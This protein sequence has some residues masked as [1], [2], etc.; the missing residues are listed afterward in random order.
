M[1]EKPT[2]GSPVFGTFSGRMPKT[3]KDVNV[4]LLFTVLT[5]GMKS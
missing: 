1:M 2:G 4:H 5:L 3:T